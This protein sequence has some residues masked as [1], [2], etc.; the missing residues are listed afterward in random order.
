[1]TIFAAASPLG[2]VDRNGFEAGKEIME[3]GFICL[4]DNC[5]SPEVTPPEKGHLA[6]FGELD[7]EIVRL[8]YHL[9]TQVLAIAGA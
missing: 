3:V 9:S 5:W 2:P 1:L 7:Y 4:E 8:P 6:F